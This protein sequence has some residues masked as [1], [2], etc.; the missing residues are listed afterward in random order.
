MLIK[1]FFLKKNSGF[2]LIELFTVIAGVAI[3]SS[4]FVPVGLRYYRNVA[5]NETV[6]VTLNSLRYAQSKAFFAYNDSS[7]GV[8]FQNYYYIIFQ[9]NSY[10]TRDLIKDKR[11][12]LPS[13]TLIV[14]DKGEE[15]VFQK[16]TGSPDDEY[17]INITILNNKKDIKITTEGNIELLLD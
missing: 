3:L 5:M 15:V 9:G 2:T 14:T 13:G 12:Y 10:E 7:F 1:L 8:K 17:L 11:V 4:L 6:L 16:G